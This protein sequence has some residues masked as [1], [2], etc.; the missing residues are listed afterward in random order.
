MRIRLRLDPELEAT[1]RPELE[2][3]GHVI[4]DDARLVLTT[5]DY[6]QPFL[7][8]RDGAERV[9]VP[10]ED[11][12][13]VEAL[14]KEVLVHTPH[15]CVRT[16]RPLYQ[17]EG[18]LPPERFLR[19]SNSVIVARSAIVRVRPALSSRFSL[20]LRDGTVVDVTRTYYQRFREYFGI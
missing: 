9:P 19:I 6:Q 4:D 8:C 1:V 13:Y 16:G 18:L 14:N 7:L 2:A 11:I 5:V 10:F 3:Q 12:F 20:T 17:L 15:Q